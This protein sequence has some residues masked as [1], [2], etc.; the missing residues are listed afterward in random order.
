MEAKAKA[1]AKAE[2]E[3][4]EKA[5]KAQQQRDARRAEAEKAQ[6]LQKDPEGLGSLIHRAAS[7]GEAKQL[8]K[9]LDRLAKEKP[10]QRRQIQQ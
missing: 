10:T 5:A 1:K 4:A 6:A 8:K 7:S 2:A 3:Q 9:L